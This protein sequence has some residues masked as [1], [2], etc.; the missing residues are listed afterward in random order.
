MKGSINGASDI[1][2]R[3]GH[4]DLEYGARIGGRDAPMVVNIRKA[5]EIRLDDLGKGKVSIEFFLKS[6]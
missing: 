1:P 5:T 2:S 6:C 3:S 4:S